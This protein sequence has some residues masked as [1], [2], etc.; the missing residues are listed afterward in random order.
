V[1]AREAP[2]R[3]P[4]Q[5]CVLGACRDARRRI[6]LPYVCEEGNGDAFHAICA[7]SGRE[8]VREKRSLDIRCAYSANMFIN[9]CAV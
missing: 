9:M 1:H 6:R 3:T 7:Y 8:Q 4:D 2:A 5:M